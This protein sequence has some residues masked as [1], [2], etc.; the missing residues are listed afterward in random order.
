MKDY[1]DIV[2]GRGSKPST[3]YPERLVDYIIE[4]AGIKGRTGLSMME[5]GVGCG[6]HL[7]IFKEKG[8][9]VR[10]L[11]I[12]ERS[13]ELSPDLDIDVMDSDGKIWP[14][15]DCSFDVIYSKS[16]IEHLID[17]ELFLSEAFR[18]LKPGGLIVTL[19]PDW[20]A[21][22]KKFYDDYTHKSPFTTVS[23]RNIKLSAG[24]VDVNSFTFRQLPYTWYNP[25]LNGL[26]A[27][28]APF[29]PYQTQTKFLRWS[30]E[31]ML[32]SYGTKPRD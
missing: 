8:F 28:V 24:F 21:N 6:D 1:L 25:F 29:V 22:Y 32:M 14:Y 31:L 20:A 3:N 23:L 5:P 7:R 2:Y 19:T 10:G 26:C 16:F 18:L 9:V 4:Q 27:L 17:P 13:K 30:R 12:S 11:D 15:E